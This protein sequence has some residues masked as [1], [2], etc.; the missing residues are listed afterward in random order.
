M[1]KYWEEFVKYGGET[2]YAHLESVDDFKRKNEKRLK[3]MK[4]VKKATTIAKGTFKYIGSA[5]D[6]ANRIAES[7]TRFNAYVSSRKSGADIYDAIRYAKDI[8]V[9]FNRKGSSITPGIFGAMANFYRFWMPFA[10]P[11]IQGMYQFLKVGKRNKGRFFT[12]CGVQ[13][14]LGFVVPMVN[15]ILFEALGGDD[16]DKYINQPDHARR[17]NMMFYIGGKYI[18]IPLAPMFRELY[19]LGDIAYST[20]KGLYSPKEATMETVDQMRSMFSLQGQS[21][22][23]GKEFSFMR[24]FLPGHLAWIADIEENTTF[25]GQPL[26]KEGDF[27]DEQTPEYQKVY[28]GTWRYLV[29][30]SRELNHFLGGTDDKAAEMSS[31]WMNPAVWQHVISEFGGGPYKFVMDVADLVS[32]ESNDEGEP[33]EFTWS[34]VPVAKRFV[35]EVGDRAETRLLNKQYYDYIDSFDDIEYEE[36]VY[37][38]KAKMGSMEYAEKL[39]ELI[40]SP[41]YREYKV[42]NG[43]EKAV[44]DL[45]KYL[46]DPGLDKS[47]RKQVEDAIERFKREV[48]TEAPKAKN[49]PTDGA[50]EKVKEKLDSIKDV[51]E[52]VIG[53]GNEQTKKRN[54]VIRDAKSNL[55]PLDMEAWKEEQKDK[56]K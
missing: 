33:A 25:T 52:D 18:K 35:A 53:D 8:T 42:K 48:L 39:N 55:E 13:M 56:V 47:D 28:N 4:G 34:K 7:S 31:K 10:N 15:E 27:I 3:R 22:M 54:R 51:V 12:I 16:E 24:F 49:F 46:N 29:E 50:S 43:Y 23:E 30:W 6:Y 40:L 45:N 14:A 19:G 37:T 1:R 26:Y 21:S 20:M 41:E 11:I 32:P 2:G 5:F 38:K 36:K 9:N 17:T 44:K